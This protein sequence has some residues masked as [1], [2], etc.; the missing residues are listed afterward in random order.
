[1]TRQECTATTTFHFFI[2]TYLLAT[3][4]YNEITGFTATTK[5][6]LLYFFLATSQLFSFSAN[7]FDFPKTIVINFFWNEVTTNLASDK[8]HRERRKNKK[9]YSG[10]LSDGENIIDDHISTQK[11]MIT[12]ILSEIEFLLHFT[13]GRRHISR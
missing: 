10:Y 8:Q 3:Y 1:M 9:I 12:L 4:V 6:S 11:I 7:H 2:F 5:L 13:R